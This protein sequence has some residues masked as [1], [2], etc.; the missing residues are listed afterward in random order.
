MFPYVKYYKDFKEVF[1]GGTLG[2]LYFLYV[3]CALW[4]DFRYYSQVI[5]TI[6]WSRYRA[7]IDD[8]ERYV[9]TIN[10]HETG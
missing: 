9:F 8:I 1:I 2:V 5:G 4:V 6:S 10:G 3:G 7:Y